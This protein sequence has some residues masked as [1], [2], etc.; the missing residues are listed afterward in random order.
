MLE[1]IR[2][3]LLVISGGGA[4]L[5]VY[6]KIFNSL[7]ID[8][9]RNK[10]KN[11]PGKQ[12]IFNTIMKFILYCFI[13]VY[14]ITYIIYITTLIVAGKWSYSTS[15]PEVNGC[16]GIIGMIAGLICIVSII[17]SPIIAINNLF[18]TEN[19][20]RKKLENKI[21][22]DISNKTILFNKIA[23]FLSILTTIICILFSLYMIIQGID[24]VN[25]EGIYI[26][27]NNIY[28]EDM[29]FIAKLSLIAVI[30]ITSFIV[31][32]SLREIYVAINQKELYILRTSSC[33]IVCKCYLE[34]EEYFLIFKDDM[35]KYIKKSQ[36]I[37]ISKIK[38]KEKT[39]N[40]KE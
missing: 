13:G 9:I 4:L 20:F 22:S 12:S 28:N 5:S 16:L 11:I 39:D 24:I 10:Y 2:N 19:E 36:V 38:I 14:L 31:L 6:V 18:K 30:N 33:E 8:I 25:K 34:Y 3:I 35:E 15:F 32:Y 26:F 40:E 7:A 29:R 37:E 23:I 1:K 17:I 27:Q 21:Y